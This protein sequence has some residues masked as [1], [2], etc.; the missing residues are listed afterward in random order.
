MHVAQRGELKTLDLNQFS[1]FKMYKR[2][3]KFLGLILVIS[4][5]EEMQRFDALIY[6]GY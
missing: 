4:F 1:K 2:E 6:C 5:L 3:Y